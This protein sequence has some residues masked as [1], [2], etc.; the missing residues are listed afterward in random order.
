MAKSRASQQPVETE[1]ELR[2]ENE[3]GRARAQE[4]EGNGKGIKRQSLK[5]VVLGKEAAN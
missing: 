2:N 5:E 3:L 4:Q 1:N